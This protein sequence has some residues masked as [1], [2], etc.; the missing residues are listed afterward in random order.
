MEDVNVLGRLVDLAFDPNSWGG[1]LVGFIL[2][3]YCAAR[4]WLK[5]AASVELETEKTKRVQL[6]QRVLALEEE[7]EPYRKWKETMVEE[8][9]KG[10]RT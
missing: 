3:Y 2:T 6:E 8:A 4:G 9:M 10:Q 5:T 1:L 7:I